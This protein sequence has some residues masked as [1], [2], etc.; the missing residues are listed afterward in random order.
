MCLGPFELTH[1]EQ[2]FGNEELTVGEIV[3]QRLAVAGDLSALDR[4]I[5][6]QTE[7]RPGE[8]RAVTQLGEGLRAFVNEDYSTAAEAL[9]NNLTHLA[10]I[11]GSDAQRLLFRRIAERAVLR[12]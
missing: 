6:A 1:H 10:Q 3:E 4:W 7:Q 11:G 12:S 5:D 2:D 9:R 8:P